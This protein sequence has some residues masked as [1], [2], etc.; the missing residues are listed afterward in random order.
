M[1][2]RT[3]EWP[4]GTSWL[5]R[6]KYGPGDQT[7]QGKQHMLKGTMAWSRQLDHPRFSPRARHMTAAVL[8]SPL[9]D[10]CGLMSQMADC[11]TASQ[12]SHGN[13]K[14][15]LRCRF[16]TGADVLGATKV[17]FVCRPLVHRGYD[18][19]WKQLHLLPV[20]WS[21]AGAGG[22]RAKKSRVL[23]LVVGCSVSDISLASNACRSIWPPDAP[24]PPLPSTDPF[25]GIPFPR[26]G[27]AMGP[28]ALDL[29]R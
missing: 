19:V 3:G 13:N 17:P 2:N 16:L 9:R 22:S 26:K 24:G 7:K 27:A 10:R 14:F 4:Q 15:N 29:Q 12:L 11:R 6:N 21:I 28:F 1:H 5:R 23:E 18:D 8:T 25:P 20:E